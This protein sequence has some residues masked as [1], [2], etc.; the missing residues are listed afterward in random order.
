MKNGFQKIFQY[1]Q[2]VAEKGDNHLKGV[3][4][5]LRGSHNHFQSPFT[6]KT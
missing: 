4:Y 5:L 1:Q 2:K 3:L 6:I